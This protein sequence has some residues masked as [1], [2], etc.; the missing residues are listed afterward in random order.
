MICTKKPL[1]QQQFDK[2]FI[3]GDSLSDDG[4]I[5]ELF[6]TLLQVGLPPDGFGYNQNYT[7]AEINGNGAMWTEEAT[8]LLGLAENNVHNFAFGGARVLGVQ[9]VENSITRPGR[10]VEFLLKDEVDVDYLLTNFG[11]AVLTDKAQSLLLGTEV[12]DKLSAVNDLNLTGQVTN[13]LASVDEQFS[14]GTAAIFLIGGNDYN[15][16]DQTQDPRDFVTDLVT[17]L[18]ANAARVAAAGANTLIYVT[19]PPLSF[20]PISEQFVLRLIG[21]GLSETEARAVLG[22]LDRLVG[23]QNQ[24]V[25]AGFEALG[26]KFGANVEIVDLAQFAQEIKAD[27]SSFG[28]KFDGGRILTSGT[29]P[30]E[31]QD[32]NNNGAPDIGVDPSTNQIIDLPLPFISTDIDG[33]GEDDIYVPANPESLSFDLDEITFID[34]FHP[35]AATQD[36]I[37]NFF[38]A[39]LTDAV[40]FLSSD[41]DR[42]SGSRGEDVI[43]AQAGNDRVNGKKA[44]DV[45]F[46]GQGD[47]VLFGS[48][49]SDIVVG[50]LGNDIL[51]GG[52][53]NDVVAGSDGDDKLRGQSG[54]DI[55]VGGDGSD[56]IR[57]GSGNDLFIQSFNSAASALDLVDGG[58][59]KDTL[60]IEVEGSDF[61]AVQ[62][63]LENF[64]SGRYF[65][66]S[67]GTSAIEVRGIETIV[68]GNRDD[69]SQ[70]ASAYGQVLSGLDAVD[71]VE[72]AASWNQ[73]DPI[74]Q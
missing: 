52:S 40:T 35:S 61:D 59:G 1:T 64:Q 5:Y 31:F 73:V 45:I 46:G 12:L 62:S 38:V 11:G 55:L 22:Q 16:F 72:T 54:R 34:G 26:Q 66:L 17:T 63:A 23:V 19:Q 6:S 70:L 32:L 39:S 4:N 53:G 36:L 27:L 33:D 41:G 9:T 8:H 71:L 57:G 10:K 2:L 58:S 68:L 13:A 65:E 25:A 67:V 44:D 15:N 18:L 20:A 42:H 43:F 49:G 47:D 48:R 7:N 21:Q 69:N 37:A 3:F 60:F 29:A 50:G 56:R 30:Q 51:R 28:F 14:S 24:Q 74:P